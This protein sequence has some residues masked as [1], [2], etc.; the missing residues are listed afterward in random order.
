[1]PG[2]L[3]IISRLPPHLPFTPSS[4]AEMPR[5]PTLTRPL[6]S[7]PFPFLFAFSARQIGAYEFFL[8][9]TK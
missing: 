4:Q 7:T 5:P 3:G 8:A 1:M 6:S 2:G 9:I